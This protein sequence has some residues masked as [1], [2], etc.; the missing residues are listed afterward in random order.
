MLVLVTTGCH[1]K[2]SYTEWL[3]SRHFFIVLEAGKSDIRVPAHLDSAG[4]RLPGFQ[5]TDSLL[6]PHMVERESAGVSSSQDRGSTLMASS[7]L[8]HLSKALP[9][10]TITY[11]V[12][13]ST[14]ESGGKHM[15]PL[16]C[17]NVFL[18]KKMELK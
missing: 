15:Q 7:E 5:E 6:H 1:N 16:Q 10:N 18:S 9:P 4:E 11:R 13:P 12:R 2:I 17:L 14:G 8:N 3:N